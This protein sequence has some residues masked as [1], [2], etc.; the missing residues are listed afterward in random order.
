MSR[1][2]VKDSLM[3]DEETVYQ[4]YD[5]RIPSHIVSAASFEKWFKALDKTAA[6]ALRFTEASLAQE[7][8][9][10][11]DASLYPDTL[12]NNGIRFP[13][14]YHFDPS[15]NQDGVTISVPLA[16]ARQVSTQRLER[17]V[18]GLLK[19]KCIA[20]IKNLPRSLRKHFVPVPDVVNKIYGRVESAEQPL[21][22]ALTEAL[23]IETGVEVPFVSWDISL[24]DPHLRFNIELV[25]EKGQVVER[26]RDL[27]SMVEKVD[28]LIEKSSRLA[29]KVE[30]PSLK[31]KDWSLD[32]LPE[33]EVVRQAGIDM[34]VFP[35]LQDKHQHV[36]LINCAD[37]AQAHAYTRLGVARLLSFRLQPQI[38][39]FGKQLKHYQK[40]GLLY[41]P[42]GQAS[43]LY[44]DFA[45]CAVATHFL[46]HGVP[47]TRADF[48][49]CYE[50]GRAD[51]VAHA[52]QLCELVYRILERYH[53]MMKLLKG[54]V[55][56]AIAIPLADLQAQLAALVNQGF[57][58]SASLSRLEHYPRYLEACAIRFEKM[59][60]EMAKEREYVPQLKQWWQ[61]YEERKAQLAKQGILDDDL[62]HFRWLIEE[63]RVSWFAQQLGTQETISPK[64][65]NKLWEGIRRA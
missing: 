45:L 46:K 61:Q 14:S 55:S 15:S 38:H 13:L 37:Q 19:E 20:L 17:L 44:D 26:G 25:D 57:L 62:E 5:E 10:D 3:V 54:K 53:Q 59:P 60:R 50:Q 31:L 8:L 2:P 63:Q 47:R 56:L 30:V 36:E 16:A 22:E 4:L 52:E 51:F 34:K 40:M 35:A 33:S 28:H 6:S 32:D 49:A 65:L 39:S 41:A 7:Q 11:F 29:P 24:L 12:E 18:P 42:I 1:T 43:D 23:R 48:D 21:L 9:A 64:R 27:L 58:A